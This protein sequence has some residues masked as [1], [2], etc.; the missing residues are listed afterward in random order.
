MR[1]VIMAGGKGTRLA[2]I[3]KNEIPKPMAPILGRP[4]LERQIEVL[5]NNGIC[6]IIM[7]IGYLGDKIREYFSDG[8]AWGVRIRYLQEEEPLG[9]AGSFY[10]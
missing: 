6:D 5:R 8:S 10:Y 3:T 4:L 7:V 2:A 9:T 1:A